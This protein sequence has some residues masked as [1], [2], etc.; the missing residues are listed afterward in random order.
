MICATCHVD[1]HMCDVA[2]WH[3]RLDF[4][5]FVTWSIQMCTTTQFIHK[6]DIMHSY[7]RHH[8]SLCEIALLYV[9]VMSHPRYFQVIM[10]NAGVPKFAAVTDSF[11]CDRTHSH[12]T[13]LI[14][15]WHGSFI[16]DMTHSYVTLRIHMWHDSFLC[17]ITHPYVTWLIHIW[18]DSFIRDKTSS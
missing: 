1:I 11:I 8:P 13:W 6:S 5:T 15:M 12:V 17:D 16:C 18:Q 10:D 7:L 3:V 4:S 9:R 14:H 2:R